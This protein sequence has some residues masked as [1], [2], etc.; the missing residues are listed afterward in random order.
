MRIFAYGTV[1]SG[2]VLVAA[3]A[4]CGST[5]E[6]VFGDEDLEGGASSSSGSSGFLQDGAAEGG[7]VT[8]SSDLRQVVDGQGQV[9]KECPPDQGCANGGC[10]AACASAEAN[11][12][13]IGCNYFVAAPDIISAGNGACFAAF[14]ANTWVTPVKLTVERA[15][16]ALDVNGMARIPSGTGQAIT[17]A[18]LTNGEIKPGEVAIVFLSR[19]GNTLT[20][21]PGGVTPGYT[22]GPANVTGTGMGQAF[23]IKTTAPIVAY[24][25]FPYGGGQSAATSATLL[26]PTSAWGKNYVGVNAYRKSQ[27]VPDGNPFL[28]I[29]GQEDGTQVEI[30]P[31]AA[32][33]AA[34][35]VAATAA[36]TTGKYTVNKGQVLQ[37]SQAAELTGSAIAADK[38]IGVT[39]GAS[40]L[41]IDINAA[42]CDSAHQALPP[43][44]ALGSRYVGVRYRNR[45]D[46][47]EESPPWR[48][49]GAV[50]GTALTWE[51]STPPGAPTSLNSGQVAEMPSPGGFVVK[52]QDDK[53]PFYLSGH[54][55]GCGNFANLSDCRGDPE[56]VNVIPPEQYLRSYVFFTD[57]TYP[58]TNLVVIRSKVN[59]VFKDVNLDCAGDLSGW[60]PIGA[61]FE[62]T[63]I[64]LVRGNFAKQGNCDNGRHEMKSD[65]PFGLTVW[66]WG[67]AASGSF[68]SQAVSYA[69]PAGASVKPVNA[70]V[71]GTGPR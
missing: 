56:F 42:A 14:I 53:H 62:F 50:D 37:I 52:S 71:V 25:I 32:I 27:L 41:S 49:V 34:G 51:P 39:G 67:S 40:C 5:K 47:M 33:A 70:V 55:T 64:D 57:P 48:L 15:G 3:I 61:D 31:V 24:D 10:V 29:V 54:M 2:L 17:Y 23:N 60:A 66:G 43:V 46:G 65:A 59:G 35:G 6:R 26:L 4:S 68:S 1:I 58:E 18:P 7:E 38:P 11:K 63:R 22:T 9:L 44:N 16:V 13:T 30:L 19:F 36:N 21:C 69:Y 20:S 8:C 28:Q 45:Y 12:S